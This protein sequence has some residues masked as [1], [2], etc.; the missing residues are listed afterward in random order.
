MRSLCK[1]CR[2]KLVWISCKIHANCRQCLFKCHMHDILMNSCKMFMTFHIYSIHNTYWIRMKL[3]WN[4]C[5]TLEHIIV[6][7]IPWCSL[8]HNI[9]NFLLFN[10]LASKLNIIGSDNGLSPGR[11]QAI[12][13]T[14]AGIF[15]IV[16]LGTN[17]NKILIEIHT[18]PFKK[19]HLKMSSENWRPFCRGLNVLNKYRHNELWTHKP[20]A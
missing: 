2:I 6:W 9:C 4:T 10:L 11:R 12:I 14:N 16:P 7:P 18:F 1:L 3:V 5:P 19:K 8:S 13:W 20:C 17:S 15:L